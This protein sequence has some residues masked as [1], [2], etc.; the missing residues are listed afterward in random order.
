M[1]A[2]VE[3]PDLIGKALAEHEGAAFI[4]AAVCL[5]PGAFQAQDAETVAGTVS[6]AGA[7][8]WARRPTGAGRPPPVRLV[9]KADFSYS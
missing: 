8:P 5:L 3:P 6:L 1:D 7:K 9:K 4:D 2:K